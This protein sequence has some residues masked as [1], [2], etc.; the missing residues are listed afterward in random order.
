MAS[1]DDRNAAREPGFFDGRYLIE[2]DWWDGTLHVG[3]SSDVIPIEY[4]FQGGLMYVRSLYL[5]GRIV[6]PASLRDR[7]I[8]VW[9][10]PFGP[11]LEFSLEDNVGQFYLPRPEENDFSLTLLL[12]QSA[13]EFAASCLTSAWK[14]LHVWTFDDD[15]AG[16]DVKNYSFS[17]D[18]AK[19]IKPWVAG[20]L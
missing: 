1:S 2:I 19:N 9:L 20:E 7:E 10:Q 8:R 3:L 6:A 16:A 18:I 4:R 13:L 12:P 17:R 15:D 5:Q 11:E 14:Y